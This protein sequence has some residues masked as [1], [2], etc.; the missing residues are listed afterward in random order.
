MERP[1]EFSRAC[2]RRRDQGDLIFL[3]NS[4][5]RNHQELGKPT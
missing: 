2:K 1:G 4:K 5:L 3:C